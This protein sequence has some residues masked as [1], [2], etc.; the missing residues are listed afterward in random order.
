MATNPVRVLI[1]IDVVDD[2]TQYREGKL[3]LS[4]ACKDELVSRIA[5]YGTMVYIS[6]L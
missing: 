5:D 3:S 2:C 4:Q 6:E 1:E